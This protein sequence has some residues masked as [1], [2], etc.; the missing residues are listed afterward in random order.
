MEEL[1]PHCHLPR[2]PLPDEGLAAKHE[3]K[4]QH[5]VSYKIEKL[6]HEGVPH[7][8]AVARALKYAR[9]RSHLAQRRH[10]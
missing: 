7:N 8:V 10:S 3:T 2:R 1:C 5:D 9:E 4:F 6:S